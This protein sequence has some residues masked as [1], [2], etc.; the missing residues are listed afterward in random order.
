MVLALA[1]LGAVVLP[2]IELAGLPGES[3]PTVEAWDWTRCADGDAETGPGAVHAVLPGFVSPEL[4]TTAGALA[5]LF[6][7]LEEPVND[8]LGSWVRIIGD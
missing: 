2:P 5:H 1:R 4:C 6:V 8:E 3:G 7:D